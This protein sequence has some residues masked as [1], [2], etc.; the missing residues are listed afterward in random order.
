MYIF[1]YVHRSVFYKYIHVAIL[2]MFVFE[3]PKALDSIV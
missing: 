3:Y 2:D 1:V